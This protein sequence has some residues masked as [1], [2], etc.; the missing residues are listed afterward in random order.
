MITPC[1]N[2]HL[3]LKYTT[4]VSV[5]AHRLAILHTEQTITFMETDNNLEE[6]PLKSSPWR[7]KMQICLFLASSILPKCNQILIHFG[8]QVHSSSLN[9]EPKSNYIIKYS[10]DNTYRADLAP[11]WK[12]FARSLFTVNRVMSAVA[13]AT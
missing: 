3:H 6:Q 11:K 8:I 9:T 2:S 7:K 10:D 5:C 4:P 13:P 1:N 12:L